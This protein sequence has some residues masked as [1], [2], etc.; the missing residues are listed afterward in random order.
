MYPPSSLCWFLA[1]TGAELIG[2]SAAAFTLLH[3]TR[4]TTPASTFIIAAAPHQTPKSDV[5]LSALRVPTV[6]HISNAQT[7]DVDVAVLYTARAH[8]VHCSMYMR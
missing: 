1:R 7:V 2:L 6:D 5:Q 3:R 4:A 8:E